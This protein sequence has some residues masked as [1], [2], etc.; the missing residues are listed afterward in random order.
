MA[1][2][3][4]NSVLKSTLSNVRSIFWAVGLFS[5]FINLLML[6]GPFYMMQV[7]DRVLTSGSI[8]TLIF[9]TIA[10]VGLTLL[11]AMLEWLRSRLLVRMNGRLETGLRQTVFSGLFRASSQG[12]QMAQPLKDL[13][14]TRG[15]LSGA[16]LVTF[17]DAP[18][19]PVFLALI[20]VFHPILGF[21]ATAGAVLLFLLAIASE[22]LTRN[23]LM[24]SSSD[25]G[26]ASQFAQSALQNKEVVMALGM[27]PGM[28]NR[29]K[30]KYDSGHALQAKAAD[31]SGVLTAISKFIRPILQ[32][33]MLGT[34]AYLALLQEISPG[35]MIASSIVM[36]RA[37]APVQGAIG[38]WKGFVLARSAFSRLKEFLNGLE[39]TKLQSRLPD[40][41]GVIS[42]ERAVAAAPDSKLPVLKGISFTIAQ[43]E[44]VGIIG[45]S[46]SGKSTLARLLVGL[47]TPTSG[48]VRLDGVEIAKWDPEELGPHIGYLPQDVEL[49]EGSVF[50]NISRFTE[51]DPEAVI[52]AAQK[53]GVHQLILGLEQGYDTNI[54]PNGCVLSGGQR[55]RIGLAR[56]LYGNP[57]LV[58][59]DEPNSNL[60]AEG[61]EAL[62]QALLG[63][64]KEQVTTV[65]I[66]HR[67]SVI[68]VVDKVLIL[69]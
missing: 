51:G 6:V 32:V 50:E 65:V 42:V 46:A 44:S 57:S 59:L 27:L 67:P 66:A 35:V 21:I 36:G 2:A 22:F 39:E 8:P 69:K 61:E 45:P 19:A 5:F 20:F 43:G 58:V 31:R 52:Q 14:T 12:N 56:A 13:E 63:L 17:F 53:A 29:W 18:W 64:K 60:D 28:Y 23:I 68:N 30:E 24:K 10:A 62:R 1:G 41:K 38:S 16:G 26:A 7:Y 4:K 55:Q 11:S 25:T 33:A 9:L 15:F 3:H 40:P 34:G 54:G 48:Q 49:F 47:W 37:L